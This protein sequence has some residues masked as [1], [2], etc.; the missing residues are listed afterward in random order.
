MKMKIIVDTHD[1]YVAK[2]GIRTYIT[3]L[4]AALESIESVELSCL[5][6]YEKV[7]SCYFF[8]RQDVKVIRAICFHIYSFLWK[9]VILPTLLAFRKVDVV[10]FPDYYAPLWKLKPLKV[11][12]FHD[13]F[14]W[15]SPQDYNPT[16][17]LYFKAAITNGLRGKSIIL[18][19]SST[20]LKMI[21]PLYPNNR[22]TYCLT[23]FSPEFRSSGVN[24]EIEG[25]YFLHVGVF[26]KRKNLTFLIAAY[27]HLL[28]SFD[29]RSPKLVLVGSHGPK[30]D[31]DDSEA[32]YDAIRY[33]QL[34]GQVVCTGFLEE[35]QVSELYK[36]AI[37]YLFPSKNEGFGIPI[38]EAF[39][40]GLPVIISNQEALKEIGGDAVMVAELGNIDKWS[41][42]M[43]QLIV[44]D[45]LR[46]TLRVKGKERLQLFS[47]EAF[48]T[49]M[50]EIFQNEMDKE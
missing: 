37:A 26:E 22:I 1:L 6:N 32:I 43:H 8:R 9:Q 47:R 10:I 41:E 7:L 15:Q 3:E 29:G 25:E 5:P 38:L 20:S 40:F 31:L 50:Q 14:F 17:L 44:N 18:T 36:G 45:K 39:Y 13:A 11:V 23:S 46:D 28:R 30:K 4:I 21:K 42:S 48:A 2:T 27:A 24:Y 35:G 49:R 12:V 16:W 19:V 33:H 34:Q